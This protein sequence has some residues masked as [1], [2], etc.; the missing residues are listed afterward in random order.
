[1]RSLIVL[2][3][4]MMCT[5]SSMAQQRPN[6]IVIYSDDQGAIDLNCYGSKDLETPNIDQLAKSGTMFTNFYASP[7]CSPSRA[8]LLTGLNP[9]RAGLPGNASELND[10][11]GMP[12]DRFTMAEM[13]K[14]AGYATAHVG[15]GERIDNAL[16]AI[17]GNEITLLADGNKTRIII[18]IR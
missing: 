1:M 5:F 7:V 15:N 4:M 18:L 3:G 12:S 8:S 13:F 14:S 2:M 9:Q 10:V 6:V 11:V 17:Q 16:L